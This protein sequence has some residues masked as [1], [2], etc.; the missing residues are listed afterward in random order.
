MIMEYNFFKSKIIIA[1]AQFRTKYGI[2]N[3][4]KQTNNEANKIINY[5]KKK[6]N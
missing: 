3:K 6:F 2:A 4:K 5:C 1:G